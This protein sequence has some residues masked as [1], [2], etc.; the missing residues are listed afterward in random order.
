MV[1]LK[2]TIASSKRQ[3]VSAGPG[4]GNTSVHRPVLEHKF[5]YVHEIDSQLLYVY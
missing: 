1:G 5:V 3:V 4:A 2:M